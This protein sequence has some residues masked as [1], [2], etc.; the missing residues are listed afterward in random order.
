M[1]MDANGN[2][3][4]SWTSN[5]PR[6]PAGGIYAREFN[7]HGMPL[8]NEIAVSP[9]TANRQENSKVALDGSDNFTVVWQGDQETTGPW[10]IFAQQFT[11]AGIKRGGEM[12]IN[13]YTAGTQIDPA[14]AMDPAG[15]FVVAWSSFGE[16]GGGYGIYA[17]QYT[18]AGVAKTAQEFR[19]NVTTASWQITPDV[20]MTANGAF[21]VVWS[22]LEQNNVGGSNPTQNYDIYARMFNADG[23]DYRSAA[24]G[25]VVGEFRVNANVVGDQMSPAVAYSSTPGSANGNSQIT[26]VWTRPESYQKTNS[27]GTTYTMNDLQVLSRL[28]VPDPASPGPTISQVG[29]SQAK[30]KISWNAYDANGV[31]SCAL[32]IDGKTISGI[33]GPYQAASGVN[34]TV[35]YGTLGGGTHSYTITA[36][37][38]SGNSRSYSGTFTL[39]VVSPTISG[40]ATSATKN[41]ISWNV[42]APAGF[43]ATSIKLDGTT[44]LKV[45]GPY[46]ATSGVNFSA[47]YGNLPAGTHSYSIVAT[48]KAG[49]ATR[50]NGTFTVAAP[51]S[52]SSPTISGVAVSLTKGTI[53]WNALDPSGIGAA[54]GPRLPSRPSRWRRGWARRQP[55]RPASAGTRAPSARRS[56]CTGPWASPAPGC[57]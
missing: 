46:T 28:I 51:A 23:T 36:V 8:T 15:D 22:S 34:Y 40:V 9:A 45:S 17:R 43:L 48:D 56:R 42:V 21:T 57:T 4:V 27:A 1:A 53:T 32:T 35:S 18:P 39:V 13:T 7:I 26:T 11:A 31:A 12:T 33:S 25:A 14:I 37:D 50:L 44:V 47:S 54:P 19:V 52:S 2:F 10:G 6:S 55:A 5:D 24:T 20:G 16:D 30:G 29:V 41:T 49:N 38:K 3:V